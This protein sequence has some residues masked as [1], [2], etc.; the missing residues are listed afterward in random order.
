MPDEA[1]P[2]FHTLGPEEAAAR[3][4]VNP[5]RGLSQVE[6]ARRLARFGPNQM[7]EAERHS[8]L[9][10]M[11]AQFSDLMTWLLIAAAVLAGVVGDAEDTVVILIIVILNAGVGFWQQRRAEHALTALRKL[12]PA[13]AL[14]WRDGVAVSVPAAKLVPGDIVLLETGNLVPADLRLLEEA[15]LKIGEAALTG[16][17]EPVEKS[18]AALPDAELP[19]AERHN[20]AFKGTAAQYGRARGVVVATGMATELGRIASLVESGEHPRTPLQRRLGGFARHLGVGA[21]I[22][23]AAVFVWG[24]LRGEP[25]VPLLLTAISLAVAAVPEALPAVVTVLL[26]LGTRAMAREHALIRHLPAVEALGSV[27]YICA[28]KTGTLT[29]NQME[30]TTIYA[31]GQ[32]RSPGA[33]DPGQELDRDLL[34]IMA[35]CNDVKL[36]PDGKPLGDP[37]ETALWS[38]AAAAGVRKAD[39]EAIMPRSAELPFDSERKRMST[40]HPASEGGVMVYVKGAPESVLPRCCAVAGA[41]GGRGTA[42][43]EAAAAADRMA[44]DGLRVLALAYRRWP[45][46]PA[47][48][49]PDT[50]ERELVL[51]GLAGML[52]P[53]RAEAAAAIATCRAAGITPVMITG[54][55]PGTAA[56]VARRLGL[57]ASHDPMEATGRG[58]EQ[59]GS[60]LPAVEARPPSGQRE[61]PKQK[62]AE[63]LLTGRGLTALSEPELRQRVLSIRVYARLDPEQKIRIVTALQAA[64]QIVAMTGDG[65][66]DAPALARADVGVAMG[67][68]GTDAAREASDLIL[69]DDNFATIVAAVHE[70][71]H[72]YDNIQKFVR[73]VLSGNLGEIGAILLAPLFGLPLPLLPI[74]IL[75]INLVTDGLPGLALA[76]EPAEPDLMQRPP[77]PPA[78]SLLAGGM[79]GYIGWGGGVIAALTLATQAAALA[80]GLAHWRTMVFTV[81]TFAQMAQILGIR[82]ERRSVF[83]FDFFSNR[84]LLMAEA[85]TLCLQLAVVY[86]P[87]LNR[88]FAPDPLSAAELVSCFGVALL[89]LIPIESEKGRRRRTG[90]GNTGA[91]P[92]I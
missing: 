25:L 74:Q 56:A 24:W 88:V 27:T 57:I 15:E 66:N 84:P 10:Q 1:P 20:M 63:L 38:A 43:A 44:T 70:G 33:L 21:I 80:L 49:T 48:L 75:W 52:D 62:V 89:V 6:A 54:D 50:I 16:E 91:A 73:F 61:R 90:P 65:V 2:A 14:A 7:R 32:N 78:E 81:L 13:M 60:P 17:S 5:A 67:R 51:T 28:D 64:R 30:V 12:A 76:S 69:L 79:L 77:R 23:C 72:L 42:L 83:K 59:S 36:G 22:L 87:A 53:P 3:L 19:L 82:S 45:R 92:G 39:L 8:P 47:D 11:L 9:R 68:T 58:H 26:A 46:P 34:R 4:G 40:L 86:T 31:G 85:V 29:R 37:T 71:R 18:V 41:N 55:H 35:L